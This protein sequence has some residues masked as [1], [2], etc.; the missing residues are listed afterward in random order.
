MR[1]A[2]IRGRYTTFRLQI[3]AAILGARE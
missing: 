2:A 3:M 1:F